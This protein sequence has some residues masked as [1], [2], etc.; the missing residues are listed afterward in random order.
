MSVALYR[1]Y[2]PKNFSEISGQNHIKITLQNEIEADRV[3]HA[4]LFC[5]PRGTGKTTVARLLAKAMNCL[6]I[7]PAGEPCNRCAN[8]SEII[9]GKAMDIIEI[10]AASH[11]GVDNVRDNII[12]GARFTP[13]RCKYKIFI[14]DEVHMLSIFAFNA[15][16][17]ILEE[18]PP[19][20]IFILATTEVHRVP[21]TIISRCQR[22]DF[23]KINYQDLVNRLRWIVSQ[24]EVRV[25][26]EVLSLVARQAGGCVRD[27]ESLL[28]QVLSLGEGSI[29]RE[30]A[31]LILPKSNFDLLAR[32]FGSIIAGKTSEAVSTINQ[33]N[34]EGVDLALLMEN[35]IEFARRLL[36]YKINGQLDE[37][38]R[39]VDETTAK[40]AVGMIKDTSVA[41]LAEMIS[42]A[43]KANEVFKQS[44]I[45]QLP[46][47]ILII[48]LTGAEAPEKARYKTAPSVQRQESAS[49]SAMAPKAGL[50]EPEEK[51]AKKTGLDLL[52]VLAK[53]P[54]ALERAREKNYSLYMSLRLG[55]P[56]A[57]RDGVLSLGFLFELQRQ[58]VEHIENKRLIKE[59]VQAVMGGPVEIETKIEPSLSL[60][61]FPNNSKQ[62]ADSFE[63][64]ADDVAREF[65]GTV[66]D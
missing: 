8:C 13:S 49:G 5:G 10:D 40:E 28:E 4:Y 22:F 26:D 50:A 43:L 25:D 51:A 34:E 27:A 60:S 42:E 55:K 46:W 37:L 58:R 20:V 7:Q 61:D 56:V 38:I 33:S 63:N 1:K 36:L 17:K 59:I 65:N 47:E 30:Q 44:Y 21:A 32:L 11:T 31:E 66:I 29:S 14:I 18:A 57:M 9:A 16:L 24:E 54:E 6:E 12:H 64:S 41:R 62:P 15:L 35:F 2:R 45:A 39:D 23:K 19:H 3:V 53:W 52:S 48:K